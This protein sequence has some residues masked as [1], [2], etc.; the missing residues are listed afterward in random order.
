MKA[1]SSSR[2]RSLAADEIP[3]FLLAVEI[4]GVANFGRYFTWS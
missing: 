3:D 2:A 4:K 1:D